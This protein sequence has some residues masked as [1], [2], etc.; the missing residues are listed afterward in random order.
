MIGF[1]KEKMLLVFLY[2]FAFFSSSYAQRT[3]SGT[4]T[5][6]NGETLPGVSIVL[7]GSTTETITDLNGAY[8][9]SVPS[10]NSVIEDL[11][12]YSLDN[13]KWTYVNTSGTSAKKTETTLI[14]NMEMKEREWMLYPPLYDGIVS[15]EIQ[16]LF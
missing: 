11:D 16:K 3:I 6:N 14:S 5:D 1:F 15:I 12:L 2:T 9:I 4:V 13:G 8:Q 7:A 10:E